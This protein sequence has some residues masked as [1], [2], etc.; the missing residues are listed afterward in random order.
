M[1]I[2]DLLKLAARALK[3]TWTVLPALGIAIST[4]CFCFSGAALMSVN[5]EKSL[6]YEL[7]V[8]FGSAKLSDNAIA[9]I[10]EIPGVTA[11]TPV[12]QVPAILKTGDYSAQL[13]LTGLD[14]AYLEGEYKQGGIFPDSSVMPYIVLN[15][16]AC[17][18][19]STDNNEGGVITDDTQIDWMNTSVSVQTGEGSRP[20]VSKISGM[21]ADEEKEKESAAYISI[22]TAE[23]LLRQNGQ[24]TI[25]SGA[26]VRIMN[27]GYAESVSKSISTLGL[28]VANSNEELQAK[29]DTEL[30][31]M[32]YLI[33][34]GVFCLLCSAVLMVA[35]RKISL[36]EQKEAY[37]TLRWIGMKGKEIG[38]LFII[39]YVIIS[40]FGIAVGILVSTS[41]PSFLSPELQGASIFTLPVPFGIAA[42]SA[43]IC[44]AIGIL[45]MVNIK[46]KL[47]NWI[48]PIKYFGD[49]ARTFYLSVLYRF[50]CLAI[51]GVEAVMVVR[52][53][54]CNSDRS[55]MPLAALSSLR[56]TYSRLEITSRC[57]FKSDIISGSIER[58]SFL[59]ASVR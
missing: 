53:C 19:F 38:R 45:P 21:L 55:S 23:E 36:L 56:S 43:V 25:Y 40:L 51:V 22:S 11:A 26:Y 27:I 18:Q 49:Q 5:E 50:F 30:K 33:V 47:L 24:A 48:N 44:I 17:K 3:G 35:W 34:I 14:S 29:W 9:E 13:T 12:L 39:Q 31:E 2:F 15:K 10:S 42:I 4:F 58:W 52:I 54:F 1:R 16:A 57:E 28:S 32:T 46:K 20:I 41:L 7:N 59:F 8:S 37:T 6:P